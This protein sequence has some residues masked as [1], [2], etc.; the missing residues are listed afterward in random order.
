MPEGYELIITEKPKVSFRVAQAL[1]SGKVV[2]E[3]YKKVSYYI[4]NRDGKNVV[5]APAVGHIFTLR[6]KAGAHDYPIFDIEWVPSYEASASSAFTKAYVDVLKKLSKNATSYVNA[7]DFDIEGSLIGYNA[8]KFIFGDAAVKKA[9]RMKFSTLT[10]EELAKAYSQ[11]SEHLDF[12]MVDAGIARHTLDWLW[13]INTSRALSHA[14]K[15]LTG[16]YLTLSAGRVQTPTLKILDERQKEINKFVPEP[17]WVLSALLTK[18]G[19]ELTAIHETE[20]FFDSKSA[21][22]AYARCKGKSARVSGLEKRKFDQKPPF[23]FNLGD[24]QTEAYK[25]FKFTP[26]VTQAIAQNLYEQGIISYPRTS[27]QKLPKGIKPKDLIK[28]IGK[29]KK[30]EELASKLIYQAVLKPNEGPKADPAHPCIYPT[31]EFPKKLTKQESALFDLIVKRFFAIFGKA[32][33]RETVTIQFDIGGENFI[34]EGTRTLEPNWHEFYQPY[35]RLKEEELPELEKGETLVVK[36][37]DLTEKET[38]PPKHYSPASIL[39][40]M[41]QI[42][43]GTKATRANI[44]QTLYDRSYIT[45]KNQLEVTGFGSSIIETLVS[46]VPE[47]TSEQLT[48][49]FEEDMEKIREGKIKKEKVIEGAKE[50]LKKIAEKFKQHEKE[51]GEKLRASYTKTEKEQA[52]LGTCPKCKKPLIIR[53][54]KRTGK[55]FVG[56]SGYPNCDMSYPLPQN[57]LII[58]IGKNCEHDGLPIIEVRRRGKRPFRMCID[59]KCPSKADWEKKKK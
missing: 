59:P 39:K 42:G 8:I 23:P 43:I 28:K 27:S 46:H 31:G 17:F 49:E 55:Q 13:G 26:K 7:C 16:R 37:L 6:Q 52:T 53:R 2:K 57:A 20:K 56:C 10:P 18:N 1:S 12:D 25:I 40:K 21:E 30:Y 35:V 48:R 41:E 44:L 24:L 36:S 19:E 15:A 4:I 33:V 58:K 5:V 29:I 3:T 47:L 34:A 54:S 51:I 50:T 11:K 38:Q 14:Y 9:R 22:E 45:G 32:A